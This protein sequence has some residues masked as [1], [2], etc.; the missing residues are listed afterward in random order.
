MQTKTLKKADN[1]MEDE[2]RTKTVHGKEGRA[3]P[4]ALL[5][6]GVLHIADP[7]FGPPIGLL[8]PGLPLTTPGGS[9]R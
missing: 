7:P 2:T 3:D 4:L 8:L 9:S 5:L 6:E 1:T